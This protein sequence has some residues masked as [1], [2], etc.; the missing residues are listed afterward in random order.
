MIL[1]EMVWFH[2]D[3]RFGRGGEVGCRRHELLESEPVERAQHF[4][5]FATGLRVHALVGGS[6]REEACIWPLVLVKMV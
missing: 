6:A 2:G 4:K 1:V 5:T 3:T